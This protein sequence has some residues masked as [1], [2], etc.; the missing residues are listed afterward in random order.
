MLLAFIVKKR[1]TSCK[2]GKMVCRRGGALWSGVFCSAASCSAVAA[3]LNSQLIHHA[4][5]LTA[6]LL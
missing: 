6:Y 1:Q 5:V 4:D 2:L 3:G